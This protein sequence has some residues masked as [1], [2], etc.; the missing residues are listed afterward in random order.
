[1]GATAVNYGLDTEI[2]DSEKFPHVQTFVREAIQNS[3]DARL[4]K[5]QPVHVRF[6]FYEG[7]VGSRADFL[8]DLIRHKQLC[9]LAWPDEWK[10]GRMSWLVVE[11]SNTSG[12]NGDLG[13]RISD[14]WNYW[15][16]FGISNKSGAGRGGRGIGRI[17]FLIASGISTVIGITRRAGDGSVAACGM[18]LLKPGMMANDFKSSYAYLAKAASGSIYKLYDDPEFVQELVE[19]FSVADYAGA[20]TSGLSL[21]I[22]FPH[23]TLAPDAIIAAA[24]EHFAPAI[25]SCSLVVEVDNEIINHSTIDDQARR[26]TA[27]FPVGPMRE[28]P[29]RQLELIRHSMDKPTFVI[30]I[31][32]PSA[33]VEEALSPEEHERLRKDF[34]A[35]DRLCIGIEVPLTRRGV[36]SVSRLCAA[37]AHTPKGRK[38]IDLFFREGMSLP[39]VE[40]RHA[41]EVDLIIQ[42]NEGELVSYLNFCEGK[43][44]L[45]LIENKEVR[46]KL[47]ENGFLDGYI[48]K[49]FVRRLMDE[50]RA[51]VLPDATQPDASVFSGYFSIPKHTPDTTNK[52]GGTGNK[53]PGVPPPPPPPS[54]PKQPNIF[55]V[56]ELPDGF[57]VRANP[58]QKSWPANMRAEIVYA[59]GSRVPKWSEYDFALNGMPI[60]RYGTSGALAIKKNVLTVRDCGPDFAIEIRGFDVRRE[61]ITNVKGFRDA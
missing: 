23:Q 6:G 51:T 33:R 48:V 2:F 27:E 9:G 11:D 46:A 30:S 44:H 42:S 1:M 39:E 60:V 38:S 25:I 26:V 5:T 19:A 16:N 61:L 3:L 10:T 53:Q 52:P 13:S 21:V 55:L 12:L 57:R 18:S 37:V 32:R 34:V 28:D 20:G 45:G 14:F 56:D 50:L 8:G 43:A 36:K 40:A 31:T 35:G 41:A 54:L 15:M 47:V 58:D 4:D 22:P 59:D 49:R 24:I 29:A 7:A 17:T